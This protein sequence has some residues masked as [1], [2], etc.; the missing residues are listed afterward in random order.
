MITTPTGIQISGSS[1]LW[2]PAMAQ[3][4]LKTALENLNYLMQ[5][6]RPPLVSWCYTNHE[7]LTRSSTYIVPVMPSVDGLRYNLEHRFVCSNAAQSV[8]V[9]VDETATYA[10]STGGTTWSN[11][12]SQV[13]VSSSTAGGLTTH[14]KTAQPINTTT[15]ALRITLGAPGAGDRTDHHLLCYPAPDA[16]SAGIKTS[17]ATPFDDGLI[18]HP[19]LAPLHT[20]WLNR[21]KKTAVAVLTDRK[22]MCLSF[23]QDETNQPYQ[24]ST[25]S[26]FQAL[27]AARIWLPNQGPTCTIDLRV[28]G[29]VAAGVATGLIEVR[30]V[31]GKTATFNASGSI[32][33]GTL[34]LKMKGEGLMT[35]ADVEVAVSRTPGNTT[36]LLAISGYY[37]P[38]Q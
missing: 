28:L 31:G 33:S 14:E 18:T 5:W 29:T 4:P 11:L 26:T 22:Q 21:C 27:P 1:Q 20:E 37:T 25:K 6:H 19:D 2:L 16:P 23:G 38:G 15:T 30:Q 34:E 32:E 8:T 10:G 7:A 36:K 9:T 13:V 3:E 12:Y 17:G 35:Y 24:W